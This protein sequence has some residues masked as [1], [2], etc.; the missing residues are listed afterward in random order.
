MRTETSRGD[1]PQQVKCMQVTDSTN[2]DIDLSYYLTERQK[3]ALA[4]RTQRTLF[5]KQATFD[6]YGLARPKN[7]PVVIQIQSLGVGVVRA[8]NPVTGLYYR[9]NDYGLTWEPEEFG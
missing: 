9:S 5:Q 3:K 8:Y 2:Q 1:P 4:N 7:A 6:N